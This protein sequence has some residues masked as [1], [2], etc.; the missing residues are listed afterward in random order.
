LLLAVVPAYHAPLVSAEPD[1]GATQIP[2]RASGAGSLVVGVDIAGEPADFVL[3][4]GAAMVSI[5]RAL[6]KRLHRAGSVV[7]ARE[8]AVR[9]ADGRLRLVPVKR[10]SQFTV[11]ADCELTD[12]EVLV[13][14]G[15]GRNLLGLNA[16]SR[17]APL[18]LDLSASSL[19][20]SGCARSTLAF[21]AVAVEGV[22]D[23]VAALSH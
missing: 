19:G 12:I 11:G 14:P 2:L 22:A 21:D 7:D 17:F 1:G 8:V 13:L 23:T 4:T 3:D 16:L 9:M 10:V 18:T 5:T 15:E 20:L 6:Y